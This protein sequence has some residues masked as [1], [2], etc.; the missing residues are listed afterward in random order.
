[1]QRPIFERIPENLKEVTQMFA[2]DSIQSL[3]YGLLAFLLLAAV[4]TVCTVGKAALKR[5]IRKRSQEAHSH[6]NR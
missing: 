1:V 2:N 4:I 3:G 6:E 5:Y